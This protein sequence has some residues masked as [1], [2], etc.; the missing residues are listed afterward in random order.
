MG[1]Y[2]YVYVY[3]RIRYYVFVYVH[4]VHGSTIHIAPHWHLTRIHAHRRH[5]TLLWMTWQIHL[6]DIIYVRSDSFKCEKYYKCGMTHSHMWRS[7]IL[8]LCDM[9]Y[10]CVTCHIYMPIGWIIPCY[11]PPIHS[12]AVRMTYMWYHS[13]MC[14]VNRIYILIG[15]I[16]PCNT[17]HDSFIFATLHMY[18]TSLIHV[19]NTSFKC[20]V[21]H[22]CDISYERHVCDIKKHKCEMTLCWCMRVGVCVYVRM[23]VSSFAQKY[24][25]THCNTPEKA[26]PALACLMCVYVRVQMWAITVNRKIWGK[27]CIVGGRWGWVYLRE[28]VYVCGGGGGGILLLLRA[29]ERVGAHWRVLDCVCKFVCANLCVQICVCVLVRARPCNCMCVHAKVCAGRVC[30][31]CACQG[32][33][34]ECVRVCASWP[35]CVCLCARLW[36]SEWVHV[37]IRLCGRLLSFGVCLYVLVC[38]LLRVLVVGVRLNDSMHMFSR[39]RACMCVRAYVRACVCARVCMCACLDNSS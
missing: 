11:I 20:D 13:F 17:W 37:C 14:V 15:C 22:M 29:R 8:Y 3:T 23:C 31:V 2:V 24:C 36:A 5:H 18:V 9:I 25:S 33:C 35:V 34:I 10:L 1:V 4:L 27:Q 12:Y 19:C 30:W 16:V 39:T 32:V 6:C 7:D 38:V 26:F 28:R 21:T